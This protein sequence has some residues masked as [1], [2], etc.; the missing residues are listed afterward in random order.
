MTRSETVGA[1]GG[2]LSKA[3]AAMKPALKDAQN[4]HFKSSYADLASVWEACRSHLTAHGIAVVQ[5]PEAD[6]PRVS[7]TTTLLHASGEWISSALLLTA[8]DASP[9]SIGSAIT[10]GRRYGL[11]AMVGVAPDD[12]DGEAAQGRDAGG[13]PAYARREE[14]RSHTPPTARPVAVPSP[15][16]STGTGD[17]RLI[18]EP[19]RKRFYAIS[20]GKDWSAEDVTTLLQQ[21]GYA[22]SK[23]IRVRDYNALVALLEAGTLPE[24]PRDEDTSEPEYFDREEAPF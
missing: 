20:K 18:S 8:R 1:L 22:T 6:G 21:H 2:A 13:T 16:S 15:A 9:Q 24:A 23:D 11:A 5:S 17:D 7:I 12:D 10:Y 3:Q 19:Q 4:P 14:P